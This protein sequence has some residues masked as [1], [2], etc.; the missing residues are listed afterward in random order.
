MY[1]HFP[2]PKAFVGIKLPAIDSYCADAN[3]TS[4]DSTIVTLSSQEDWY[5]KLPVLVFGAIINSTWCNLPYAGDTEALVVCNNADG[6]FDIRR[7]KDINGRTY[8]K[9]MHCINMLGNPPLRNVVTLSDTVLG[10]IATGTRL[11][12]LQLTIEERSEFLRRWPGAVFGRSTPVKLGTFGFDCT[13]RF[14]TFA[15]KEQQ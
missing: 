12:E 1:L 7:A 8:T 11:I 15:A 3:Q 5:I 9:N 14:V 13:E 6:T 4:V 10:E 2:T